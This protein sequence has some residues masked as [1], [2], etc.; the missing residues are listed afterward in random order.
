MV[1]KP[2]GCCR[3][4]EPTTYEE[5]VSGPISSTANSVQDGRF[6]WLNNT[7]NWV[8]YGDLNGGPSTTTG[9]IYTPVATPN[10]TTR[11]IDASSVD[12]YFFAGQGSGLQNVAGKLDGL[13][14][15]A[16]LDQMHRG[17]N[18]GDLI[19]QQE[20]ATGG[21]SP[22]YSYIE[23]GGPWLEDTSASYYITPE[24][25]NWAAWSSLIH[26]A[27]GIVY[28]NH[29]FAGPAQTNDI[30]ATSFYQTVQPGQT[31]S[32]YTQV[33]RTDALITQLAPVLN[34]PTALG[35]VSTNKPGYENG[36][37]KSEFS[38]IETMAKAYNGQF[39]IFAD[40]RESMTRTNISATFTIADQNATSVTVVNE[41]RTIP[42]VNG[43][44]TDTFARA[45]TVHIYAVNSTG[46]DYTF[47]GTSG[48]DTLPNGGQSNAGNESFYGLGGND[49][50]IGGTGADNM[51]GGAGNDVY[52]VDNAGDIVNESL[53][54]SN[55]TDAVWSTR[56][57][58]LANTARVMG[59]VEN[60]TLQGSAGLSGTGNALNNVITGNSGANLLTGGAGNDRLIGGAGA[61]NMRGGAGSDVYVVDNAG[62]IV[63]ENLA[64]SNGT[65]TVWSTRS[66]SLANTAHAVGAVENL[67][68]Q[69]SAGFS[70]T[71]N[72]LNNVI[73]GNSGA[74]LLTGGA[75]NDRLIGGAGADNM[76]G[77]AGNDV[78]VVDNAGDIVSENLAGSNGTDTVWST[79]SFSLANTAHAVGAVE[80]LTL[81]GSAGLSGTGNALNNVI[82]GN[83]GANLL[84]GGAGNDR[85]IGGAGNDR[86][87]GGAGHDNFVFNSAI[88][89]AN[90]VDTISDFNVAQDTIW[91]DNA[92]MSGL[93]SHLGTLSSPAFWKSTT[94]LAHDSNDH[95]IYETDTGWLNY[96]GNGSAAGGAVHIA[97]LAPNLALSYG[98]FFVT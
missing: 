96:D 32:I 40:T 67:T 82:T 72:A 41:N 26:G 23:L 47:M 49:R 22:I 16:T 36:V 15:A 62:D 60:L 86:L 89:A 7:S 9:E 65:D 13:S 25:V 10:G 78:Y 85:L 19:T 43:V 75:G 70:G 92:V 80:N 57:F 21:N 42:V 83:S 29:T 91:L 6:W 84:T 17:N 51:R 18:Y 20:E 95:I 33:D 98:D 34:S 87:A 71:G 74:N 44:F 31:V 55:G 93:G 53:A 73:T 52:L 24:E 54:G 28:F 79:R 68:L 12:F 37:V 14:G 5:G 11:H 1:A 27:R 35:Y 30:L 77:G 2:L 48:N 66:F 97:K 94:G 63:S 45:S 50:L 38:G 46:S 4:D 61:D 64:G 56:S 59:A 76:R 90:N 88:S 3:Y 58:S 69:G 81:Q 39:F 8:V